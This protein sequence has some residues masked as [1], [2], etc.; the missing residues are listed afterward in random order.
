VLGD[1]L[2]VRYTVDASVKE[3]T[4]QTPSPVS[5][6]AILNLFQAALRSNGAALV[7]TKEQLRI[8]PA[9]QAVAGAPITIEGLPGGKE[10]VGSGVHIVPL[11]YVAP[12]EIQRILEPMAPRGGIVRI[13]EGRN[14]VTL[15][16]SRQ[17]VAGM[18]EAIRIFD[19]D[20]MKGMSFAL[21][22]V[23][24]SEPTAIVGELRT[25]FASDR[26]GPMAGMVRFL[27]NNRLR[28]VL[29][30]TP[31]REYLTRAEDWVKARRAGCGDR[32]PVLH[33]RGAKPQGAGPGGRAAG[34]AHAG[35]RRQG[36]ECHA[37]RNGSDR[38]IKGPRRTETSPAFSGS[39]KTPARLPPGPSA[40]SS[41]LRPL[42]PWGS[43]TRKE[44]RASRLQRMRR[45]TRC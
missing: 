35:E 12:A 5:E 11:K 38:E 2:A 42:Q 4:I 1:I 30:I 31:Q 40:A 7:G 17:E 25:I 33:L 19:I 20:T 15:A 10:K 28:A 24:T 26:E 14:T 34:A 9:D 32:A 13:D 21:I 37:L 23:R 3:I 8:V 45:R 18:L 16:G 6:A 43:T 44:G 39:R 29:V 41:P 36:R 27:P 22:P